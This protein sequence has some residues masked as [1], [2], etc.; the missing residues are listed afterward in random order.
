[1]LVDSALLSG[2]SAAPR[3]WLPNTVHRLPVLAG[4]CGTILCEASLVSGA[5]SAGAL[6]GDM[7]GPLGFQETDY[8]S[9][10]SS[11]RL[12]SWIRCVARLATSRNET[13]RLQEQKDSTV[14]GFADCP[15]LSTCAVLRL[16]YALLPRA[17]RPPGLGLKPWL[18]SNGAPDS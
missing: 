11:C 8:M 5:T 3:S 14:R 2:C 18:S 17:L 7:I 9:F 12:S 4:V 13:K 10:R 15:P 6:R 1:M 16:R